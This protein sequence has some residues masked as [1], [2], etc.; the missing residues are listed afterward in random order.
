MSK[1]KNPKGRVIHRR[2]TRGVPEMCLHLRCPATWDAPLRVVLNQRGDSVNTFFLTL[3]LDNRQFFQ[4][5]R[6]M[7][8]DLNFARV[9]NRNKVT[10]RS[11]PDLPM[12]RVVR[13]NLYGRP[14]AP[15][16]AQT[17]P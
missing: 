10:W 8:V 2:Q 9:K 4:V 5:A 16:E 13:L 14:A 12:P 6:D 3:L 15:D 7:H 1:A 11:V 17:S